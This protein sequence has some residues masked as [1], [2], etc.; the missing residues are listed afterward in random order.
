MITQEQLNKRANQL[1]EDIAGARIYIN[2]E[3]QEGL[4]K[5]K[6]IGKNIVKVFIALSSAAGTITKIEIYDKDDEIVQYEEVNIIKDTHYKFLAVV[7]IRV[8]GG[9]IDA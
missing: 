8:E 6:T 1:F 9:T 3:K 2:S 7:E 5:K 4:I